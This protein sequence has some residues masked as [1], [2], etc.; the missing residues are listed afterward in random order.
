MRLNCEKVGSGAKTIV[1]VHGFPFDNRMWSAQLEEL[2]DEFTLAAPDMR[3]MGKS[4][5]SG[6]SVT[7][8]AELADDVAELLDELAIEKCTFCGLSMG[9]YVGW[10]F[11]KRH[12]D[13]LERFILCDSGANADA[14]EGAAK[15][16]ATAAK[17]EAEGTCAFLVDGMKTNLMTSQTLEDVHSSVF[18]TFRKMVSENNPAGTAAVARG[19]AQR[20]DF[21]LEL[22]EISVPTLVMTGVNDVLSPPAK[23]KAIADAMPNARFVEIPFAAHLSPMENPERGNSEIRAFMKR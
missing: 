14:S 23:M 12:S 2:S 22:S 19:M 3:G 15:R 13:R 6:A 16:L 20:H 11:W 10:E 18:S 9:G 8:M 17:M 5:A 1:F 4:A 21:T 7:T